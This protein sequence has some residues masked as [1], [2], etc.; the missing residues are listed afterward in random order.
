MDQPVFK[1]NVDDI[2]SRTPACWPPSFW[3]SFVPFLTSTVFGVIPC[4]VIEQSPCFHWMKSNH[5]LSS[6]YC[7]L[8]FYKNKD[9]ETCITK[10]ILQMRKGKP[11]ELW[12]CAKPHR[13]WARIQTWGCASLGLALFLLC[14]TVSLCVIYLLS[15]Y[16]LAI[17]RHSLS[18][19]K[20][21]INSSFVFKSL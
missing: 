7:I 18:D 1:E 19:M 2:E 17:W 14:W 3:I 13:D 15:N 21:N 16:H 5:R 11:T 10:P 6:G 9:C 12:V 4:A 20:M 8:S